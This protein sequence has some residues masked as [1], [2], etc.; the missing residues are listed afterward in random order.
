M[1]YLLN[2]DTSGDTASICLSENEQLIDLGFNESRNDHASWLHPAIETML[3]NNGL[4]T[5]HLQAVSVSIGPG[6]YTG[7]RIALSAAKGLCYALNIPLITID[8]LKMMA[9][10][11]Q[12]E[13]TD[14]I[15]PLID[16]RRMEVYTAVYNKHLKEETAPHALIIDETSFV[17]LLHSRQV[18]FCGS[19]CS[20]LQ[21]II[22]HS[23]ATI[24]EN[25]ADASHLAR[26]AFINYCNNEFASVA[27]AEPLYIKEFY[28]AIRKN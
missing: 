8:T 21:T 16:A 11:V 17:N 27:Y 2:I 25:S 19:G 5:S 3:K 6:S 13:A 1:S 4:T 22:S 23:N 15:C 7:L 12:P 9:F 14:L 24:S 28:S 10:A 26:L 20:K 18:L